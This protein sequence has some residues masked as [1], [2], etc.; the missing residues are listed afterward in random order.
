MGT[1]EMQSTKTTYIV[2]DDADSYMSKA[3]SVQKSEILKKDARTRAR[4]LE[5]SPPLNSHFLF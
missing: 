2:R 4:Y 1:T 5:S 3:T